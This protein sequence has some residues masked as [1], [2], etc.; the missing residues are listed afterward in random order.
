MIMVSTDRHYAITVRI[1]SLQ[2]GSNVISMPGYEPF[3]DLYTLYAQNSFSCKG[4]KVLITALDR[5]SFIT[6][7]LTDFQRNISRRTTVIYL[8]C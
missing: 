2:P 1:L 3:Y 6:A 7:N 5:K 4:I 8:E